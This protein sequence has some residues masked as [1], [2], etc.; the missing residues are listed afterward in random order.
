MRV[1][2]SL[3]AEISGAPVDLGPPRQ[4]SVLAMLT[5]AR[6]GAVPTERMAAQLWRGQP[7]AKATVSL[8]SYVSNLRR[9]LEPDRPPRTPA[10]VLV[11]SARGYALRLPEEA[12]DAWRFEA[13]VRQART[14]PPEEA[15]RLLAEALGWWRGPA[16]AETADEAWASTE[17]ARLTE[18]HAEVRELA[19]AAD[20][21]TGRAAEAAP[22]AEVLVR[23]SPLREEG[24]RLLAIAQWAC[25]R[26]A[27]AL[28][29]LRRAAALLRDELGIDPGPGLAELES[30]ILRQRLDVLHEV[31]P[32]SRTEAPGTGAA[33]VTP[34]EP[35][36]GPPAAPQA[37]P[38]SE[39]FVG[40][41]C[42]LTALTA[43]ARTAR[44]RGGVALVTG[45]PG[46]GK[47]ALL[48]QVRQQL[49]S[50]GWT[51]VVG[52]CP[53]FDGAQPAWAWVEAL[54]ALARLVPPARPDDLAALLREPETAPSAHDDATAGRFHLHRAFTAWL[55]AAAEQ[56]PLAVVLDD[57]HRADSETLAL[58]EAAAGLGGVP[59]LTIAAYRPTEV[60]DGLTKTLAKLAL[61]RPHRVPLGG[62][63]LRDVAALV[64]TVCGAP[65]DEATVAV[66][67]ERTGGNPFYVQESARLLE[68]E[69]ALVAISEVPQGVRDVLRRRLGRLPASAGSML[70]LA[71]VVGRETEVAV[72]LDAA[73]AAGTDEQQV[74]D[75]LEAAVNAGLLTEPGPGRVRFV[76]ALVRDTVY[77][78]LLGVRR[79][80]LHARVAEALRRHR[81]NDFAALAHHFAR[82]GSPAAAPLAVDY[83]LR[84]ADLAE[85]RYTYD[86]AIELIEQA[87]EASRSAPADPDERL[88][89]LV[90]L[91]ERRMQAQI[92]AGS[93][94][95]ARA[96]REQALELAEQAGR[97]D[98]V[99]AVYAAWTEPT[100]W[101][102]RLHGSYDEV[103]VDRLERLTART[104]VDRPTRA[105][106]LQALVDELVAVDEPRARAAA[107]RQ[108]E[109]ARAD[110][111]PQLLAA[112][113]MTMA[114]PV[115]HEFQADHRAPL[116]AELR[117][118]AAEHDLPAYQWLG[119]HLAGTVC[120]ARND[121]AGLRRHTEE[122]LL[123]ARRY[124]ML[125][126]QAINSS[127]MAMLAHVEGRF[128]AAEAGYAETRELAR[129]A[130]AAHGDDLYT[131]GLVT[132]RLTQER[133]G[134][135]EAVMRGVYEKL[136]PS[137]G[138]SYALVLARQGR[139]EEARALHWTPGPMPDHLY[140][141]DIE[142]RA[143]LAH[144]LE[145][146]EA[147]HGLIRLL[148][149]IRGQLAGGAGTAYA[150]RP[151]AHA[152]GDLC[153]L[154]GDDEAAAENYALAEAVAVQWGSAHLAAGARTAAALLESQVRRRP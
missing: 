122:G 132:V 13:A 77:T 20:L 36:Y 116:V 22:T 45:E 60:E 56:A 39:P 90:R 135:V 83:S 102:T 73:G 82:S 81:P 98:L 46:A 147:A 53:E 64:A 151:L 154:V 75:G 74:F 146:R 54:T 115:P 100:P 71:S 42:E 128:E 150:T 104:D 140:G 59:L 44:G 35:A 114:K 21:R 95:A 12:V 62:L 92:R 41:A 18:L 86:L 152:L 106:L 78:D 141:L 51:V 139:I 109:L 8:Q 16:F 30:A 131:L 105:R 89:T 48:D 33:P 88:D 57:L 117:S 49:H 68:S 55:R 118:L 40:R 137:A 7:P 43:F 134:E 138:Y 27:D 87:I 24:W 101:H 76:H 37:Q 72:L 47:S 3:V 97:D 127:T 80:R 108:L 85:R 50:E 133:T 149:P 84:A 94:V 4:R 65:V 145:D 19:V 34:P 124:R 123:I 5:A 126:A 125:W 67:A 103:A 2:G 112:A 148:L 111:D 96:S 58:L 9:L 66:L 63:P 143:Q 93:T 121:V 142:F 70:H 61:R 69:G 136:G 110:G 130:G 113:L 6:G 14:A 32:G 99:A 10:T 38:P 31:A 28:S 153:R 120:G 29:T 119:E 1:L 26:Q 23:D 144:L 25:G 91:L 11:S 15:R 52:R 79:A 107:V 17:A 129:R